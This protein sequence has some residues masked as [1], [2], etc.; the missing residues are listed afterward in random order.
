ML[1][2]RQDSDGRGPEKA[3]EQSSFVQTC[4]L[5]SQFVKRTGSLRDL[6]LEIGGKIESLEAIV[7]SRS[8]HAASAPPALNSPTNKEKSAQPR[9]QQRPSNEHFRCL[10]SMESFID[11]NADYASKSPSEETATAKRKIAQLT[12][13]YGGRVLIFDDYPEDRA[14]ELVALAK[15]G[16]SQMSYGI[17]SSNFPQEKRGA[18]ARVGLPPRPQ[19]TGAH[20]NIVISSNSFREKQEADAGKD[21]ESSS[22]GKEPGSTLN[23]DTGSDMPIAR[24]SSLYRFLEKRKDR[25]GGR[26]S[27]QIQE[28]AASS[29]WKVDEQLELKL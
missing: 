26:V 29:S 10:A 19:A 14:K 11:I 3:P 12:M 9:T 15:K 2:P 23:E 20:K 22:K 28:Q 8:C 6:N 16:S 1:K 17:F 24:R 27:Y 25:A 13:F 18:G 7:K 4:N 5:L 21:V